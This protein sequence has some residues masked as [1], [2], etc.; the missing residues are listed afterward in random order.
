M[1]VAGQRQEGVAAVH[2]VARHQGVWVYNRRQGVRHGAGDQPD[3]KEHL[4]REKEG[5]TDEGWTKRA[6]EH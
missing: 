1:F 2:E 6:A 4:G 5:Q 3:H